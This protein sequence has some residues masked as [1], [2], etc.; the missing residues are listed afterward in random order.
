MSSPPSLPVPSGLPENVEPMLARQGEPF[1]SPEHLFE[2]KWDGVR[3]MSYAENGLLRMHGRRRRDLATRYPE[4]AFLAGLPSG[5]LLDGELVV[6]HEDGR[7]NFRAVLSRENASAASVAAK[8]RQHPVVFVV[9][10]LL[11]EAGESLLARPL[12]ERRARLE[13]LVGRVGHARLMLSDG[14][15]E[16]GLQLFE[17]AR[18]RQLEGIVAKHLD[19]PYRPGERSSSWQKIK[20]VHSIHCL[21]LGYE[22]NPNRPGSGKRVPPRAAEIRSLIIASDFGGVLQCVGKVGSG[23]GEAARLAL[24]ARL[25]AI[26]ADAP[27]VDAAVADARDP[28][29]VQ[30]GIFCTVRYFERTESGSLRAPVFAGLVE[31]DH[32]SGD[33]S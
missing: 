19:E 31:Q 27:L 30:P 16:H 17:A 21:V 26:P 2:L 5:M 24:F 1:D 9:F 20:P 7:P 23:I 8:A 14:V 11:F 33:R 4:L 22:R 25:Q 10:D 13:A 6:L 32:P 12:R 28:V 15:E 18:A 3:C 29:W